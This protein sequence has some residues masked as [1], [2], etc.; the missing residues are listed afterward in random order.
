MPT[1][2]DLVATILP[3]TLACQDPKAP[4]SKSRLQSH[5]VP[6]GPHI[7]SERGGYPTTDMA[8]NALAELSDRVRAN[9]SELRSMVDRDQMRLLTSRTVGGLLPELIQEPD[10]SKH[11]PMIRTHLITSA[12]ALGQNAVHYIP[13][14]LFLD[15]ACTSFSIGPVRFIE[16]KD[17][18]D[19]ITA[20]RRQASPW[21]IGVRTLWAG[22][23]LR[24]GSRWAGLKGTW[25]AFRRAP[26]QPSAWTRAYTSARTFSEPKEI[27]D[28]R[29]VA[30]LIHPDQW[31]ACAEVDGFEHEES[32]RRGLLAA[33]VALDTVRLV[34]D[35]SRRAL[36]STAADSVV[37]L[38][39]ERLSQIP[40]ADL[41]HGW[42]LNR[43]GLGG[44]PGKAQAIV[45]QSK[46]LF[47][48]AGACIAATAAINP[49]HSCPKLADRWFNAAHWFG[50]ACLA[51]VDF[52][53]VVMLVVALDVLCGGLEEKGILE[54][55]ARLTNTSM[56]AQAMSD[57][58]TLKQLVGRG[59]KLRS[60]VAH[61]SILA[62]HEPLDVER[63]QLEQI[64]AIAIAEYV[65]QLHTYSHGGRL[66]DRDAFLAS[67]PPAQP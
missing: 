28:A 38:S 10:H 50:R 67:L 57:G 26:T 17:W 40:G 33:R 36:I 8:M 22:G 43:P 65:V 46:T 51:D 58:T 23:K 6:F 45:D 1:N 39:V 56:S 37:P 20:R 34:L 15:Q 30:R 31:I 27:R 54:L 66:D 47:D 35:G 24:G 9:D 5:Y 7:L 59:Y 29:K 21:M 32:R 11:W 2:A 53:A 55:I 19:A 25:R 13:A 48:A 18:L 49:V 63:A 44:P 62:L 14:W 41:A 16:R 61:G 64:A 60:E 3:Q 42:R 4:E 52:T 12:R